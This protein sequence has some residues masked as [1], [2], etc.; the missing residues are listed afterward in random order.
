MWP[1]CG[2]SA[3][4]TGVR[5]GIE[6]SLHDPHDRSTR[7]NNDEILRIAVKASLAT[8]GATLALVMALYLFAA[9][10]SPSVNIPG[11]RV[12]GSSVSRPTSGD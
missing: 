12:H 8:V 11:V 10:V 7:L 5:D 6:N 3:G 1:F 9:A 2:D 4:A